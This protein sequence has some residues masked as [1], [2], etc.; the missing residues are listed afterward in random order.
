[1]LVG[2]IKIET[3]MNRNKEALLLSSLHR[4]DAYHVIPPPMTKTKFQ[5]LLC[6]IFSEDFQGADMHRSFVI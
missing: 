4:G 1:M 2:L 3:E 6:I 5:A